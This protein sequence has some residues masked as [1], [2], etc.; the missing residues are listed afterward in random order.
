MP[1]ARNTE[2]GTDFNLSDEVIDEEGNGDAPEIFD[3]GNGGFQ[4]EDGTPVNENGELIDE[5]GNVIEDRGDDVDGVFD[6]EEVEG[7]GGEADEEALR[8][9]AGRGAPGNVPYARFAEVVDQ[10]K[11]MLALLQQVTAAQGGGAAATKTDDAP[12]FDLKAKL[13]AQNT[14]LME[15]DEETA[16]TLALEIEDHRLSRATST[17]EANAIARVTELNEKSAVDT[18]IE[19]GFAKYPFLTEANK[20]VYNPEA[21]EEVMMWRNHLLAQGVPMSVALSRALDKVGP[22]YTEEE[23]V[24]QPVVRKPAA[25]PQLSLVQRRKAEAVRR[26]VGVERRTPGSIAQAGAAHRERLDVT[27]LNVADMTD[28]EYAALPEAAKA[29]LRGD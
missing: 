2:E 19:Q 24:E 16:L 29:K 12:V 26:N 10:N 15:G 11:Q 28:E 22:R 1:R 4:L 23:E 8:A 6:D 27:Q 17:A 9:V 7:A 13:R 25:K 21:L 14:A 20:D 5:E 18:V 3:D